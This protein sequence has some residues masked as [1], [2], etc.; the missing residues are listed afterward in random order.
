MPPKIIHR[1][2]TKDDDFRKLASEAATALHMGK[3]ERAVLLYYASCSPGFRP[4]LQHIANVTGMNRSQ[5]YR[6]RA[7]LERDG[8]AEVSDDR[9]LLDWSRIRIFASL[10][11]RLTGKRHYRAPLRTEKERLSLFEF[12]Y[13]GMSDLVRKLAALSDD[14]YAALKQ[15]LRRRKQ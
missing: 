10:D 1:A 3:G 5:V 12:F 8:I 7:A 13:G 9:V 15:R 2:Y 6:N 11:P 14:D 4:S